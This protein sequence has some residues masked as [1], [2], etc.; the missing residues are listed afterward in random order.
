MAITY[1]E[2]IEAL[3]SGESGKYMPDGIA[4]SLPIIGKQD[5]EIIDCFFLFSYSY[6]RAQFNSPIARLANDSVSRKL[7]YYYDVNSRPFESDCESHSYPLNF[8]FSKDERRTAM[9][10]YQD[11]YI[12]VRAFAFAETINALQREVLME[13]MKAFDMLVATSQKRFYVSLSPDFFEWMTHLL[14]AQ[15]TD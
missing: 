5:K 4:H 12:S 13:Y 9:E 7:I 8:K 1:N 3:I 14:K 10:Q 11:S 15:H 6:G 2:I